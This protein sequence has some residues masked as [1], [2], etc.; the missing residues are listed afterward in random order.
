MKSEYNKDM[1]KNYIQEWCDLYE[2]IEPFKTKEEREKF[3]PFYRHY[4]TGKYHMLNPYG[5]F[6]VE[7]LTV[8]IELFTKCEK[9]NKGAYMFK[10]MLDLV[11]S[12]CDGKKDFYQIISH[13]KRV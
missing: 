11:K 7:F 4:M 12:Y 13:S 9:Q 5:G 3:T 10:N 8:I 6:S 2:K 1:V